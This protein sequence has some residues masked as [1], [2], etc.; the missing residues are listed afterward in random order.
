VLVTPTHGTIYDPFN[1]GAQVFPFDNI[2]NKL[3]NFNY[4]IGLCGMIHISYKG[5]WADEINTIQLKVITLL[6]NF[7]LFMGCNSSC[8]GSFDDVIGVLNI[9]GFVDSLILNFK[10][11]EA[12][13]SYKY[14]LVVD[15]ALD[16]LLGKQITHSLTYS[17]THLLTYSLTHLLTYSLTH[18]YI[19]SDRNGATKSF[20]VAFFGESKTEG[21]LPLPHGCR[22]ALEPV[23]HKG[24]GLGIAS[25]LLQFWSHTKILLGTARC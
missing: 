3:V 10:N 19:Y 14:A 23:R 12:F 17:L 21:R 18:S 13:R 25:Y 20:V 24:G 16:L 9:A 5:I 22:A 6:T 1:S 11:P 8:V 4:I 2:A 15:R 7:I